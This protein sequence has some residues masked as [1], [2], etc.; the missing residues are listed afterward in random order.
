MSQLHEITKLN[1]GGIFINSI[2][3]INPTEYT[4]TI[5]TDHD[6]NVLQDMAFKDYLSGL[7]NRR[8]FTEQLNIRI[9]EFERNDDVFGIIMIDLDDF[10]DINNTHGHET[11]DLII[12]NT[13]QVLETIFKR[14]SDVIARLGGDEFVVLLSGIGK[15]TNPQQMCKSTCEELISKLSEP[16]DIG[17]AKINVTAS[18]GVA[19][20]KTDDRKIQNHEFARVLL[21]RA[22]EAM[23][24]AKDNGKNTY[25]IY[26]NNNKVG[27]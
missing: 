11:G 26:S 25:S 23:Y 12:R 9:A 13:A 18:I 15:T 17:N 2:E 7:Y 10:T 19:F 24:V 27:D 3:H 14:K 16:I 20:T 8:Y 4:I 22:D 1:P 5:S 21:R 6:I